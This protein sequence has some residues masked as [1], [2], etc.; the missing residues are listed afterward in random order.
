MWIKTWGGDSLCGERL[1][2]AIHHV[3]KTLSLFGLRLGVV[4]HYV[5]KALA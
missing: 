5:K 4:I 2:E 1:G 3:E